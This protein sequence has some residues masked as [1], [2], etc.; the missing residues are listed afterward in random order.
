M[1]EAPDAIT[2]QVEQRDI[3]RKR[4]DRMRLS[5]EAEKRR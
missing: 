2:L 3:D 5:I 1:A 4:Y